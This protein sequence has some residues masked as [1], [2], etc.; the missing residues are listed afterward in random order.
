MEF[1]DITSVLKYIYMYMY[2]QLDIHQKQLTSCFG[3]MLY[4][5]L[6]AFSLSWRLSMMAKRSLE[7]LFCLAN[8][9]HYYK[10]NVNFHK[11]QE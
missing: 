11:Y 1:I 7:A 3:F 10:F 2:V 6:S 5:I 4:K 9:M 8:Y